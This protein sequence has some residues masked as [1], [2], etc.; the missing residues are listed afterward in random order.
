MGAVTLLAS[1][2]LAAG[3]P[4][5]PVSFGVNAERP[6]EQSPWVAAGV[7]A[8]RIVGFLYSYEETLGDARVR[9]A[10]G[11]VVYAGSLHKV[12][13][14][15]RRWSGTAKGFVI[16]GRRLDGPGAFRLRSTRAAAPVFYPSS[17]RIP[18]AG[19]WRLTLRTG[20]RN[21]TLHVRA[22]DA[23][24]AAPCDT[25]RV[26]HGP[27]PSDPGIPPW[28]AAAPST[29]GIYATFSVTVA[30]VEGAAIYAGGSWPTGG[31]TKILWLV[32]SN[33][34]DGLIRVRGVRLDGPEPS[35]LEENAAISPPG[36][37][38]SI[39][40]VPTAGYSPLV[41]RSGLVGGAMVFRALAP[42]PNSRSRAAADPE[43]R[44]RELIEG[45]RLQDE[46]VRAGLGRRLAP[47]AD[48]AG[49]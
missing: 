13:W 11:L 3:C 7:G 33:A 5:A 37:Y 18:S 32:R 42:W 12:A 44:L 2:V 46:R 41:V 6:A 15:P 38:P 14:F 21:W 20:S 1:A 27:N 35:R 22:V 16:E 29:V 31:N 8:Q 9:Q 23:P 39:P 30:G 25:S 48:R 17:L 10:P 24:A 19:C 34:R 47:R 49:R 43:D 4:S 45:R 40:V 26:Q 36:V 28:V